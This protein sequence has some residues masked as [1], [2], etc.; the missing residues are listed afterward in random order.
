MFALGPPSDPPVKLASTLAALVLLVTPAAA[1]AE[2][3]K[4]PD[5]ALAL[6]GG[7]TL[8]SGILVAA[9]VE[10]DALSPM[11]AIGIAGLALG[12]S[13]GHVYAGEYITGGLALRA[14]G[15]TAA[16]LGY[17]EASRCSEVGDCNMTAGAGGVILG[18]SAFAAGIIW[19]VA[20]APRAARRWNE[21]HG[22]SIAPVITDDGASV[23]LGGRF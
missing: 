19:D 7:V 22:I 5:E 15:M 2:G 13:L 11:T 6:S 17:R 9:T 14:A 1:Q 18:A 21:R 16:I 4:S 8:L 23:T 12:P 10:D 3:P 20:T